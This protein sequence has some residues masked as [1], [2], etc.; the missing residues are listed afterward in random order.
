MW[1]A[2][3]WDGC[4]GVVRGDRAGQVAGMW[5]GQAGSDLPAWRQSP[6]PAPAP[7]SHF[8]NFIGNPSLLV[9]GDLGPLAVELSLVWAEGAQGSEMGDGTQGLLGT[10]LSGYRQCLGGIDRVGD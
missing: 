4:V 5:E 2:A 10:V 3:G 7:I 6:L 8:F 1:A 9:L